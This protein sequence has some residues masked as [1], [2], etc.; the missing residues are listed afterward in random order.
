MVGYQI[1]GFFAL[2]LFAD[3]VFCIGGGSGASLGLNRG[4]LWCR[5]AATPFVRFA[6][7][8]ARGAA[9]PFPNSSRL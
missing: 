6:R 9:V 4:P 5:L 1:G 2:R 3:G 7:A 8:C